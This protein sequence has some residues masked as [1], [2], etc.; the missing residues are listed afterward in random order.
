MATPNILSQMAASIAFQLTLQNTIANRE[1]IAV[2]VSSTTWLAPFKASLPN[3]RIVT[4]NNATSARMGTME[5]K[6][7]GI[8]AEC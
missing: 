4:N 1:V 8:F 6:G 3:I 5:S 7:E 2:V